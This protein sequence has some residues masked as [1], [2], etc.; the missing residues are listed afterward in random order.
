MLAKA[1]H[2]VRRVW[3][4]QT[5]FDRN[6]R[7]AAT[8]LCGVTADAGDASAIEFGKRE[9]SKWLVPATGHVAKHG[10][11][12]GFAEDDGIGVVI[13]PVHRSLVAANG[14][15]G[16]QFCSSRRD[17]HLA[18]VCAGVR[19]ERE[20]VFAGLP[21]LHTGHRGD[22]CEIIKPG[23]YDGGACAC[24]G[25][26]A[27]AVRGM[28]R[29]A[30]RKCM[31]EKIS[32]VL[33]EHAGKG[34]GIQNVGMNRVVG[35]M[36]FGHVH[37]AAVRFGAQMTVDEPFLVPDGFEG[38]LSDFRDERFEMGRAK[39]AEAG[40]GLGACVKDIWG[41]RRAAITRIKHALKYASNKTSEMHVGA[42]AAAIA[43][44]LRVGIELILSEGPLAV[45]NRQP[46]SLIG[47]V[48]DRRAR[49]WSATDRWGR[50][51]N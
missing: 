25:A 21:N 28:L 10:D 20:T 27:L 36:R 14:D 29:A 34:L 30:F 44:V 35:L 3:A 33:S 32:G 48:I 6:R 24:D 16:G 37:Q 45:L 4:T 31:R 49:T 19:H 17:G 18:G 42:D 15:V 38:A 11:G 50:R 7:S 8:K 12:Y 9:T 40:L 1:L 23:F 22:G 41:R 46:G 51:Q 13:A 47:H 39:C 43:H 2:A 5:F 26:V